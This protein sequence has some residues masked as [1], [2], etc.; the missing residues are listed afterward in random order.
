MLETKQKDEEKQL[1]VYSRKVYSIKDIKS[2]TYTAPLL[3]G[4]SKEAERIFGD[5][6]YFGG[7]NLISRHPEDYLLY[8]VGSFDIRTGELVCVS[9]NPFYVISAKDIIESYNRYYEKQKA[10]KLSSDTPSIAEADKA[11]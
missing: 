3:A 7:D 9:G 4:T 2:D 1:S 5:M 11:S 6:C 10:L 8:C